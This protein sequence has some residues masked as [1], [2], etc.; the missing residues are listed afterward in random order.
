MHRV[1]NALKMTRKAACSKLEGLAFH[2]S[3]AFIR[4]PPT[5]RSPDMTG[6]EKIS[7][8]IRSRTHL[9]ASH[10]RLLRLVSQRMATRCAETIKAAQAID[11]D[12][13]IALLLLLLS[14]G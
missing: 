6:R 12:E 13:E 8:A 11:D 7:D 3:A 5:Q 4:W 9:T 1:R 10:D 14:G 2:V